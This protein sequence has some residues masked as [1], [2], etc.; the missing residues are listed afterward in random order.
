MQDFPPHR[1]GG[2]AGGVKAQGMIQGMAPLV[3][4]LLFA[5]GCVTSD[6]SRVELVTAEEGDDEERVTAEVAMARLRA[7]NRR[8][9]RQRLRHPNQSVTRLRTVSEAQHPYAVVVSCS[10]SRV[11]P[12][13]IF[14][15]GLGDLF[16]VREAGHVAHHTTLGSVEYAVEHLEVSLVVVLGHESCGA[17]AATMQALTDHR[18]AEGHVA[19]LVGEIRPAIEQVP[20]DDP[21]R[22]NRAVR[23]NVDWVVQQLRTSEPTLRR[24]VEEDRVEVVGAIYNLHTG[25]VEWP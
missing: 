24:L 3:A 4:A 5:G 18:D 6:P 19:D 7:G 15:E 16:V 11:P 13:I 23:A 2:P 22:M 21:D 17:V 12:E 10:D 9:V 25:Q 14:D 8:F 1:W 20:R